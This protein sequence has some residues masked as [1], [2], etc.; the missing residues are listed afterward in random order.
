M[1]CVVDVSFSRVPGSFPLTWRATHECVM[2]LLLLAAWGVSRAC[3][4]GAL[5]FLCPFSSCHR[6]QYITT[7]SSC[8]TP[9]SIV[10][11]SL[12]P[13][14]GLHFFSCHGYPSGAE[15]QDSRNV[16]HHPNRRISKLQITRQ[17]G[18]QITGWI[19][20]CRIVT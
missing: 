12:H 1:G 18:S 5:F 7:R 14:E 9:S 6:E 13:A 8:G 10:V 11:P 16:E 15:S 3:R 17:A 19:F 4:T 20:C 2:S